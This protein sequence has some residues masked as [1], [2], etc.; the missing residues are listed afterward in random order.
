MPRQIRTTLC[1][2]V[3]LPLAVGRAEIEPAALDTLFGAPSAIVPTI[4]RAPRVDGN[5]DDDSWKEA[6][7]QLLVLNSGAGKPSQLTWF[8]AASDA[9]ALYVAV[10]C[11]E[12]RMDRLRASVRK[13]DGPLWSDDSVELLID[14]GH[15]EDFSYVHLIINPIGTVYHARAGDVAWTPH[16]VTLGTQ[17]LQQAW[18][19][20]IRL[21]FRDLVDGGPVPKLWG[22][23]L[24]RLRQPKV[25]AEIP[26]GAEAIAYMRS[27]NAEES[28]WSPTLTRTSHVPYRFGQLYVRSGTREDDVLRRLQAGKS[29]A[30]RGPFPVS[31]ANVSRIFGGPS[32]L[33]PVVTGA[34][35]IDG[36]LRDSAWKKASQL[37]FSP[38][39]AGKKAVHPTVGRIMSDKENLYLAFDCSEK[40][41]E[42]LVADETRND[43][44]NWQEDTIEIFLDVGHSQKVDY[45]F[46]AVNAIGA[47]MHARNGF[48]TTWDP[49]GMVT[50]VKHGE[51]SWTV[52]MKIPFADLVRDPLRVPTLWGMNFVRNRQAKFDKV[53]EETAWAPTRTGTSHAPERFGH[54]YFQAGTGMPAQVRDFVKT[55]DALVNE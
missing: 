23:N 35:A 2:I 1:L 27:M 30:P 4:A 40:E 21:P 16:G 25:G 22:F 53:Y 46:F 38:A 7:R 33:V 14:P 43:A 37:P 5:L 49:A 10:S 45:F 48:D 13:T 26:T 29:L 55:R 9:E 17:R 3:A 15:R 39:S 20:E 42:W 19:I 47:V 44:Y 36:D 28:A 6:E 32:V 52:E 8:K 11:G 31:A 41:M 50:N 54:G 34:P 18:T 12:E 24:M 51:N